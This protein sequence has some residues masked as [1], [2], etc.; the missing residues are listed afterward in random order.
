MFLARIWLQLS[1]LGRH[2]LIFEDFG[3]KRFAT[4]FKI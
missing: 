3:Q 2:S 1:S 4:E